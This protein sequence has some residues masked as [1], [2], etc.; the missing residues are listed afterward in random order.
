MPLLR[1]EHAEEADVG[2]G[3]SAQGLGLVRDRLQV[4]QGAQ[5]QPGRREKERRRPRRKDAKEAKD[6]K[7]AKD[8]KAERAGS[9]GGRLEARPG[10]PRSPR[11]RQI[12]PAERCQGGGRRAEA[13]RAAKTGKAKSAARAKP[14][15]RR[16][17]KSARRPAG[18]RSTRRGS[19]VDRSGLQAGRAP[20]SDRGPAGVAADPRHRAGG[21]LHPG[22]DGPDAAAAA[23]GAAAARRCSAC[24][25]PGLGAL[26]ALVLLL[27]TGLLV[28]NIIGRSLV[29]LWEDLLNRIPFVRA[30]LRRRE[31]LSRPRILSNSGNS[32]KKVLLIEYPRA[33]VWS[34]G[35]QTAEDVPL[36]SALRSVRAA[37]CA[38]SFRPRRIRPP[39]S[40]S[41]CRARRRS[42]ST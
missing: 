1:Q 35:F 23:A 22:A 31:E 5:A 33:G 19:R 16:P 12:K 36:V 17:A 28:T 8:A 15:A 4:R 25:S 27:L 34:I 29:R 39:A 30:R 18:S 40:S 7:D 24:T 2:A 41:W 26:L 42:S 14:A 3:V 9:Q 38:C 20:L 11:T 10:T 32:F 13:R 6:D 21:A 37:W